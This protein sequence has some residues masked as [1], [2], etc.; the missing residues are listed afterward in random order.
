MYNSNDTVSLSDRDV[1][2]AVW[3]K[4]TIVEGFD[5]DRYRKDPAGA[6]IQ[7]DKYGDRNSIYGWEIDHVYPKDKGGTDLFGNL[8]AMNWRNNDSKGVD[9]PNYTA[10]VTSEGNGNI[11]TDSLKTINKQ[12]QDFI[13]T[14]YL[15]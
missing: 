11:M 1:I 14:A 7:W 9:Y 8:R 5:K 2:K 12:T 10:V 6:F 3:E 13:K 15:L 4:A